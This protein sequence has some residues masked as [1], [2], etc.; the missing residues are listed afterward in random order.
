MPRITPQEKKSPTMSKFSDIKKRLILERLVIGVEEPILVKGGGEFTAKV[1][2]GN[3]GLNVIHGEDL[4]ANGDVLVFVTFDKDGN[5]RRISKKIQKYVDVNI[6]GGVVEH[7]PVVHLDIKFADEDYKSVPFSVTNRSKQK[8]KVLICKDFVSKEL[9][10]LID[11]GASNIAAKG[12]EAELTEESVELNEGKA[13]RTLKKVGKGTLNLAGKGLK[14]AVKGA[15]SVAGGAVGGAFNLAT[16]LPG[17]LKRT[18]SMLQGLAKG[19]KGALTDYAGNEVKQ[20]TKAALKPTATTWN[21]LSKGG[22]PVTNIYNTVEYEDFKRNEAQK[23]AIQEEVDPAGA[24]MTADSENI[25]E[26]SGVKG[27]NSENSA[28]CGVMDYEGHLGS[29]KKPIASQQSFLKK[30]KDYL[31]SKESISSQRKAQNESFVTEASVEEQPQPEEQG[32]EQPIEQNPEEV[33]LFSP[34]RKRNYFRFN[35]MSFLDG[36]EKPKDV[37]NQFNAFMKN[38]RGQIEGYANQFFSAL[39]GGEF[40][41]KGAAAT[42]FVHSVKKLME[43]NT[44]LKGIFFVAQGDGQKREYSF[45]KQKN[46]IITPS[47]QTR[48]ATIKQLIQ[49][50]EQLKNAWVN[51]P[52]LKLL[53]IQVPNM[54]GKSWLKLIKQNPAKAQGQIRKAI[55]RQRVYGLDE[56]IGKMYT[57]K[58]EKILRELINYF[59]E[60][61]VKDQNKLSEER[62]SVYDTVKKNITNYTPEETEEEKYGKIRQKYDVVY[63]RWTKDPILQRV[64]LDMNRN[65]VSLYSDL[66]SGMRKNGASYVINVLKKLGT[67]KENDYFTEGEVVKAEEILQDFIE[68]WEKLYNKADTGTKKLLQQNELTP[69]HPNEEA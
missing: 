37:S 52:Y 41:A 11:P 63:T 10:A 36:Q 17:A 42:S 13:G 49:Q 51:D 57:S 24:R 5:E 23:R 68:F 18:D 43:S 3:S 14:G 7:R 27:A 12:V 4:Y 45:Y 19:E 32:E 8:N 64:E 44:D 21:F 60:F 30:V 39:G 67:Y 22:K 26:L 40:D 50:Y 16:G 15:A 38:Y 66:L 61:R 53:P 33:E 55:G 34:F 54:P 58:S 62:K 48:K 46:L 35:F 28:I 9:D 31:A 20:F 6:G 59:S 56:E 2:S 29:D 1:D 47:E 65:R 69:Y 25:A